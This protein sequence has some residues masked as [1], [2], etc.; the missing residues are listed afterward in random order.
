MQPV[1]RRPDRARRH[2]LPANCCRRAV[3]RSRHALWKGRVPD[4]VRGAQPLFRLALV[5]GARSGRRTRREPRADFGDVPRADVAQSSRVP[6]HGY[7]AWRDLDAISWS[8]G[9]VRRWSDDRLVRLFLRA[10]LW[11]ARLAANFREP[12]VMAGPRGA[13]CTHNVGHRLQTHKWPM[14]REM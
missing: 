12:L 7:A 2:K 8:R 6:R 14:S 3:V 10:R 5:G 9:V 1:G 13:R 4:L 11:R